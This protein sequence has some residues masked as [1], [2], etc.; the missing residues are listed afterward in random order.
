MICPRDRFREKAQAIR[1]RL[2]GSVS[3]FDDF[4]PKPW[5]MHQTRYRRLKAR[6]DAAADRSMA[7]LAAAALSLQK[8]LR[9]V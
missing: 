4:P 1:E 6:H 2:G 3:L 8:R 5:G 7:C 9:A